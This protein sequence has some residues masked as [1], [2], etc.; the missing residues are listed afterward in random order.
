ML[1]RWP[2]VHAPMQWAMVSTSYVVAE[3]LSQPF[4][5]WL[6]RVHLLWHNSRSEKQLRVLAIAV[7]CDG[8]VAVVLCEALTFGAN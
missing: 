3:T 1:R 8:Q 5:P 7:L 2:A 4:Q 6:Q